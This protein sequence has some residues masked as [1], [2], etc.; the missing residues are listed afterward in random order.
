MSFLPFDVLFSPKIN[1]SSLLTKLDTKEGS[2]AKIIPCVLCAPCVWRLGRRNANRESGRNVGPTSR[3]NFASPSAICPDAIR[4]QT[5]TSCASWLRLVLRYSV[6]AMP[7]LM[8]SRPDT[9]GSNTLQV[10][11]HRFLLTE[12]QGFVYLPTSRPDLFCSCLPRPDHAILLSPLMTSRYFFLILPPI[13]AA[14]W[15]NRDSIIRRLVFSDTLWTKSNT[16]LLFLML[17]IPWV[18]LTSAY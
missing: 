15:P 12:H 10:P 17:W 1:F 5:P 18:G 2:S 4:T 14:S 13:H 9:A 16:I 11:W 7:D 6:L 8:V 3:A